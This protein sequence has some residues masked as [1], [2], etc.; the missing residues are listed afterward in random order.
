[1]F[2]SLV[3]LQT[4]NWISGGLILAG[5]IWNTFLTWRTF[6]NK[7]LPGYQ[8]LHIGIDFFIGVG[9]FLA[10]GGLGGPF[11]WAGFLAVFSIAIYYDLLDCLLLAILLFI[12]Q[13]VRIFFAEGL[14]LLSLAVLLTFNLLAAFI[15]G[16]LGRYVRNGQAESPHIL[17]QRSMGVQRKDDPAKNEP[18]DGFDPCFEILN[19]TMTYQDVLDK[20]LDLCTTALGPDPR[21]NK[22]IS[23]I[24]LSGGY[25]LR[26]GA[27]RGFSAGGGKLTFHADRG[28]FSQVIQ[29]ADPRL[30]LDPSSDPELDQLVLSE[31]CRS[32]LCLPL[33]TSSVVFGILLFAHPDAD[34]FN[35]ERINTLK[36]ISPKIAIAIQNAHIYQDLQNQKEQIIQSHDETR[37]KLARDLHDGPTQ[38]VSA[39]AMRVAIVRKL[40]EKDPKEADEE[41]VRLEELAQRTVQ[42]IRSMLFSLRPS[43]LE[44]EG[45][46]TALQAMI[47]KMEEIYHQNV[48]LDVNPEVIKH[49]DYPKQF[50]VF[51]LAEDAVNEACKYAEAEKILLRLRFLPKVPETALLEVIDNGK[52]FDLQTVSE[53]SDQGGYPGMMSLNERIEKVKGRFHIDSTP[54]K[55]TRVFAAIPLTEE[56]SRRL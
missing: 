8:I 50:V 20:S 34:Y 18:I 49:M 23:A 2:I 52:G 46:E 16:I 55:G 47:I 40:L 44:S 13:A 21:V 43:T 27:Q 45:L 11:T 9:L 3:S 51:Q 1:M 28:V 17:F 41:L 15:L 14:N 48:I 38:L 35:A 33:R 24:L 4:L 37:Q 26:L 32:V 5:T 56:A 12:I 54:G 31:G 7:N 30:I 42:D 29:S 6:Q 39:I 22:L 25:E 53:S 19:A 36:L 10:T